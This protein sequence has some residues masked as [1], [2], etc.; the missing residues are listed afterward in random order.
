MATIKIDLDD[1]VAAALLDRAT[2]ENRSAGEIVRDALAAFLRAGRP[3]PKGI[4][5]YRSGQSDVSGRAREILRDATESG[6]WP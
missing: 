5:G 6:Q 4:G 2:A 1:D 3:L